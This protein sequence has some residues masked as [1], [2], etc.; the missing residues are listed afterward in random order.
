MDFR[1]LFK[2]KPLKHSNTILR[3]DNRNGT[4]EKPLFHTDFEIT[5][6]FYNR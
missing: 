2:L 3:N 6:L 4:V 5:K 1:L